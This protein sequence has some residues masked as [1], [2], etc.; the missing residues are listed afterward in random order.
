M[1]PGGSQLALFRTGQQAS[2]RL[3][4]TVRT[5]VQL[6]PEAL[7]GPQCGLSCTLSPAPAAQQEWAPDSDMDDLQQINKPWHIRTVGY[8][9]FGTK[10]RAMKT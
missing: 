3:D 6:G 8:L 10:E 2:Q 4:W 7:V 5:G 1:V 9:S